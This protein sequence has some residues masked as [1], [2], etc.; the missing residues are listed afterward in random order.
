ML[1]AIVLNVDFKSHSRE[2]KGQ[3]GVGKER[4]KG[5]V[6]VEYQKKECIVIIMRPVK[7][8]IDVKVKCSHCAKSFL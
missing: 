1:S 7:W 2:V 6:G 5:W 8:F 3:S 4:D